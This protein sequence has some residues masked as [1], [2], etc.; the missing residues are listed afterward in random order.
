M[1]LPRDE[2][3]GTSPQDDSF[4]QKKKL[5]FKSLPKSDFPLLLHYHPLF[6]YRHQVCKQAD[7]VLAHLLYPDSADSETQRKSFDYYDAV[8]T[9]DSSLSVCIYATQAARLGDLKRAEEGFAATATLDLMDTHGNTKDGL[10]TA[11][12]GGAYMAILLGFAGIRATEEG[13]SMAPVLPNNWEKYKLPLLYHGRRLNLVV[14]QRGANVERITGE[15]ITIRLN[16]K[17]ITI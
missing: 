12:L 11:S 8:T 15:P 6:I 5:D 4:L 16:G 13:L 7:T 17:P 10:H 1:R 3:L 14:D 2:A 9:H